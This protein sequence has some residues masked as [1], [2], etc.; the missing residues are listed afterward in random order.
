MQ[1][2]LE[3]IT[4]PRRREI[5][6]LVWD[7]ELTAGEIAAR[8]DVSWA[9]V[10]QNLRVL[11]EANLVAERRQG[12]RRYYRA[13]RT[14][15]GPL[16]AVLRDMWREDL[17]R[18]R[19][20]VEADRGGSMDTT[21]LTIEVEMRVAG[22]PETVF[23]FFTDAERYVRWQGTA[24]ELDPTPGGSYVV[25]MGPHGTVR[26]EYRVVEPPHRVVFT[27]GWEGNEQLPPGSS[28][29]EVTLVADGGET[30]VRLRHTGLPDEASAR[31]HEEGWT[32]YLSALAA[33]V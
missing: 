28:T 19:E 1:E 8:F 26:G 32:T 2:A 25:H 24:A 17:G 18:L 31:T 9:A 27:W 23:P 7:R 3:A 30:V 11:R 13:D 22:T 14:A 33:T 29:V 4:S 12:T 16:E 10:S 21:G 20:L 6:R 5:L 15:L